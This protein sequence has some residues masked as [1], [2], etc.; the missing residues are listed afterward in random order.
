MP[1]DP[2]ARRE[3]VGLDDDV[4]LDAVLERVVPDLLDLE[5]DPDLADFAA[6]PADLDLEFPDERELDETGLEDDVFFDEAALEA[7]LLRAPDDDF[8][9]DLVEDEPDLDL[10]LPDFDPP[11]L[12]EV[13]RV[14]REVDALDFD[15]EDLVLD[16]VEEA[17]F[18]A[19]DPEGPVFLLEVVF[20][21]GIFISSFYSIQPRTELCAVQS[22]YHSI[23]ALL[24]NSEDRASF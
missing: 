3:V 15:V 4:R 20:V 10:E 21:C 11:D 24:G 1:L 12:A 23:D 6:E 9:A 8:D 13:D 16:P 14:E 22:R 2:S 5:L 18:L 17:D 7:E 19:L